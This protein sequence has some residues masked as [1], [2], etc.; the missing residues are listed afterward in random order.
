MLLGHI[1]PTTPPPTSWND[2]SGKPDYFPYTTSYS[3]VEKSGYSGLILGRTSNK[4]PMNYNREGGLLDT[5][6]NYNLNQ[7]G[8]FISDKKTLGDY[9]WT[10]PDVFANNHFIIL[11]VNNQIYLIPEAVND[12]SLPGP[13]GSGDYWYRYNY[14]K[15]EFKLGDSS[16]VQV[17]S[18]A[19][20]DEADGTY[21]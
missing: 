4:K 17:V 2:I 7:L 18:A 13:D 3:L 14:L 21:T 8:Q 12:Y 1:H 19:Y 11:V 16:I 6:L 15:L 9:G 20:L 5:S 10:T